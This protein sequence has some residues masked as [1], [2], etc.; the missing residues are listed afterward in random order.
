VEQRRPR[1]KAAQH[2]R[3]DGNAIRGKET[4][5]SGGR[6]KQEGGDTKTIYLLTTE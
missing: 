5:T 4:E 2:K 6:W 3:P 1:T